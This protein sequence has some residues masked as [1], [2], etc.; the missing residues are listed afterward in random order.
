MKNYCECTMQEL[1]EEDAQHCRQLAAVFVAGDWES[2]EPL[3]RRLSQV[4]RA[5]ALKVLGWDRE[6]ESEDAAQ[7]A[8]TRVF[9]RLETWRGD[10]RLCYFVSVAATRT[11]ID[12]L[13]RRRPQQLLDDLTDA[14]APSRAG[15]ITDPELV[16]RLQQAVG[17]L[18]VAWQRLVNLLMDGVSAKETAK[19]LGISRRSYYN[20]RQRIFEVLE[21]AVAD[22]QEN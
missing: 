6:A 20:W 13:R 17:E 8:L 19:Q 10:C 14:A 18:P 3:A 12:T 7:E 11:A 1:T 16:A 15:E 2:G 4:A 5:A 9:T 21:S 22:W